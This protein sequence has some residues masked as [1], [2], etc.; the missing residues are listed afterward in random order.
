MSTFLPRVEGG[1]RTLV[2]DPPWKYNDKL[3]QKDIRGAANHYD[4]MTMDDVEALEIGE[5]SAIN[6]HLYMWT[7]NAFML[8]AHQ[9]MSHWG[10]TQKTILTWVKITKAGTQ[11]IGMGRYFRNSTEHCL[12][13]VKGSLPFE[14]HN[15]P[16]AFF[17]ERTKHSVK[18]EIFYDIVRQVSPGPR[19]DVFS[20]RFI[21]GFDIWGLEAPVI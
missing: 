3:S 10:F 5:V 7:T 21:E 16:S 14:V 6:S 19:L 1:Y 12:F 15:V 8:E 20:R 2:V 18:P 9:L 13:G 11:R 4:L 17:A